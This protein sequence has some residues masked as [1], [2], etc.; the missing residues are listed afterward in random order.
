MMLSLPGSYPTDDFD[1]VQAQVITA[2]S[3]VE[4]TLWL[5]STLKDLSQI[6]MDSHSNLKPTKLI[7][8]L[9]YAIVVPRYK[10]KLIRRNEIRNT[11]K[12]ELIRRSEVRKFENTEKKQY[13]HEWRH[14]TSKASKS[15]RLSLLSLPGEIR[16]RIYSHLF[17]GGFLKLDYKPLSYTET[18][19]PRSRMLRF[20]L[21]LLLTCYTIEKE[22]C[23]YVFDVCT[24]SFFSDQAVWKFAG[25]VQEANVARIQKLHLEVPLFYNTDVRRWSELFEKVLL[26]KFVGLKQIIIDLQ[27]RRQVWVGRQPTALQEWISAMKPLA[28]IKGP[29]VLINS[30]NM[31]LRRKE[32]AIPQQYRDLW[33]KQIQQ[34]L[35]DETVRE[36]EKS[37]VITE[38]NMF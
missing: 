30:G 16:N 29:G 27:P 12:E 4:H 28:A 31:Q 13:R 18:P 22:I 1:D 11:E 3:T 32:E 6:K 36:L 34:A 26:T 21:N 14:R 8:A 7:R 9:Q 17:N 20:G 38:A 23:D 15:T 5:R 33:H 19:K 10:E 24:F 35:R 25:M 37:P 2:R